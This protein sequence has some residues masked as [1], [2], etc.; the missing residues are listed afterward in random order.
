MTSRE[1]LGEFNNPARTRLSFETI[2]T[3]AERESGAFG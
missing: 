3:L 2:V 1:S